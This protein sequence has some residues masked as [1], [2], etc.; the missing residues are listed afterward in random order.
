MRRDYNVSGDT[1]VP[2]LPDGYTQLQYIG[3]D[4]RNGCPYIKTDIP[5]V[6]WGFSYYFEFYIPQKLH[7][8]DP[9]DYPTNYDYITLHGLYGSSGDRNKVTVSQYR[10]SLP[11]PNWISV[12]F[13]GLL[14]YTVPH[15]VEETYSTVT[16]D[17]VS[18]SISRD[19][20]INYVNNTYLILLN[21]GQ[22]FLNRNEHGAGKLIIA[23]IWNENGILIFDGQ[24]ALRTSDSEPGLYDFAHSKFHTNAGT[25]AFTYA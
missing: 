25:G 23:K 14:D 10:I 19:N 13:D 7:P 21:G 12:N 16:V 2:V 17:G 20:D 5:Y 1:P 3:Y 11:S 6:S 8:A 22:A 9:G 24:P 15:T 4:D 18:H